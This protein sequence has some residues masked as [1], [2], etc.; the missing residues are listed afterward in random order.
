[1]AGSLHQLAAV[2]A[3]V[4]DAGSRRPGRLATTHSV[5]MDSGVRQWV[6][7]FSGAMRLR[8]DDQMV[9]GAKAAA[10]AE[11]DVPL[12][13][14]PRATLHTATQQQRDQED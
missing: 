6:V 14:H 9:A 13:L 1:M 10:A 5:N 3:A 12:Q 4:E 7:M 2:A 11:I 8:P